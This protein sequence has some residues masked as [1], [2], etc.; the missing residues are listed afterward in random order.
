MVARLTDGR[1]CGDCDAHA[2]ARCGR[3]NAPVC[4]RHQPRLG[5]RCG[6]CEADW[7]D[8][9]PVRRMLQ[10]LFAPPAFVL[11]GGASFLFMMPVLI[12]LPFSIGAPLVATL[13]ALVGFGASVGTYRL[14]ERAA[15]AQFLREHA[16][17]LPVARV[18]RGRTHHRQLPART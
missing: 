9:L 13:A 6:G 14:V 3:C 18:V 7:A 15:R 2:V 12:A 4:R 16:R 1:R 17:A 11:A 5:Q 8:D 10:R